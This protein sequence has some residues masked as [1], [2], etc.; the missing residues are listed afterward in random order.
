[1]FMQMGMRMLANLLALV[2]ASHSLSLTASK[3]WMDFSSCVKTLITRWPSIISS[4]NPF[5]APSCFCCS[6]KNRPE[7]E[8]MKRLA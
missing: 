5:T 7:R 4:M 2:L 1:M 3:S 8:E 6:R